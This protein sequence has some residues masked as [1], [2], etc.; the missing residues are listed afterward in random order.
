[1]VA[2][3]RSPSAS[4]SRPSWPRQ[5][6]IFA[7]KPPASPGKAIIEMSASPPSL[8]MAKLPRRIAPSGFA[9][10]LAG[11]VQ[12]SAAE[13]VGAGAALVS[14]IA[15]PANG[16]NGAALFLGRSLVLCGW[17]GPAATGTGA[18]ANETEFKNDLN[19]SRCAAT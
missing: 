7:S 17:P 4:G 3:A 11:A 15:P 14:G 18:A 10:Q 13:S 9:C 8:L 12:V 1:M 6:L 2:P 16:A 19:A 5:R